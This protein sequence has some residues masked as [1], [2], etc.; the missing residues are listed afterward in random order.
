VADSM[1]G[2]T[3]PSSSGGSSVTLPVTW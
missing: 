1:K 3:F 2:W